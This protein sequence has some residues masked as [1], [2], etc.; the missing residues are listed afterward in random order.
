LS[1]LAYAK[2]MKMLIKITA[3][4]SADLK[5]EIVSDELHNMTMQLGGFT[6]HDSSPVYSKG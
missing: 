4:R 5:I 2:S 3:I 6:R 1:D